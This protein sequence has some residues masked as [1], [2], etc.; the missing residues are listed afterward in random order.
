MKLAWEEKPG[1]V[2]VYE[3]DDLCAC[4]YFDAMDTCWWDVSGPHGR[5]T[6]ASGCGGQDGLARARREAELW[7]SGYR[8]GRREK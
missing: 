2:W 8:Q 7:I 3:A 4:V 1:R 5:W 6:K